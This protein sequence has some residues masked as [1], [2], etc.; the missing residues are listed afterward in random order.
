MVSLGLQSRV[1]RLPRPGFR[2]VL[3]LAY[4]PFEA[5]ESLADVANQRQHVCFFV[6]D[7]GDVLG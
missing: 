2:N 4:G 7:I 1:T 6:F 5:L 3:S